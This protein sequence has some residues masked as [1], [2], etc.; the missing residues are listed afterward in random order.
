MQRLVIWGKKEIHEPRKAHRRS[1]PLV[2]IC[3]KCFF[4][5]A[6]ANEQE[7]HI[8]KLY[9]FST[10]LAK[11]VLESDAS[12]KI[13]FP[14]KMTEL[15]HA[16]VNLRPDPPTPIILLGRSGTGKT[17]C[18]LYRLWDQF[19]RYWERAETY[20]PHFPRYLPATVE[21]SQCSEDDDTPLGSIEKDA[22]LASNPATQD[23]CQVQEMKSYSCLPKAKR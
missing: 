3:L 17:T 4:P 16:I 5:P 13:G 2:T 23:V 20:A 9:P 8:L 21:T 19:K 22:N 1:Q 7:Y 18:C 6:S 14:F 10:A 15:E 11:T 12:S